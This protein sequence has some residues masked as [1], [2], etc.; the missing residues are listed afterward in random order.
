MLEQ[1]LTTWRMRP[2]T[3][4]S[5]PSAVAAMESASALGAPFRLV[6]LD[7][8]M[9]SMDGFATATLMKANPA[10]AGAVIMMVSSADHNSEAVRC[11]DLGI[12]C[13]VRNPIVPSGLLDAIMTALVTAPP[14]ELK[15]SRNRKI[16]TARESHALNILVVEDNK[17]NQAVVSALLRKRGHIV[18]LAGDG[19]LALTMLD[20]MTVD[21]VFMD[22]HMP[23]M[24]GFAA[25]AAIREREKVTGHHI[26]I[27]ALTAHAMQGDRD[28]F[29]AAGMDDYLSKPIRP[30]DLDP[31]L[32]SW[33]D[34]LRGTTQDEA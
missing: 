16:N 14:E 28:R 19:R 9:P 6:L 34:R 24:D 8:L 27:V 15:P 4:I 30:Q 7:T 5:G 29:L 18:S 1:L 17:V 26:P 3:M 12:A 32:N 25:T 20:T 22:I 10:L 31:I 21:L 13:Y 33:V 11:R 2:T 23:E